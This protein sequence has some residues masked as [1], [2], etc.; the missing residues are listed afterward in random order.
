M[1]DRPRYTFKSSE[2][3]L[4]SKRDDWTMLVMIAYV[5]DVEIYAGPDLY[6]G[7]TSA[8]SLDKLCG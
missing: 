2:E 3:G 5:C 6:R 7:M 4:E 1:T 8:S